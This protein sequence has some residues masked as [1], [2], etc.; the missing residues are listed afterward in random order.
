MYTYRVHC[1]GPNNR[2]VKIK[3]EGVKDVEVILK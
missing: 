2:Y 3:E 1:R